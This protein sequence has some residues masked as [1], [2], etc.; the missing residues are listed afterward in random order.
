MTAPLPPGAPQP[1]GGQGQRAP[2]IDWQGLWD[3][4]VTAMPEAASQDGQPGWDDDE[5]IQLRR[6]VKQLEA[7]QASQRYYVPGM[8]LAPEAEWLRPDMEAGYRLDLARARHELQ[9]R[10]DA[11]RDL[12]AE[13]EA[14]ARGGRKDL[15]YREL[16]ALPKPVWVYSELL[17]QGFH[18]LAGPPEAGKSLLVRNWL[19]EIAASG[20]SVVFV[21]SEGQFDMAERFGSH[22][23]IT[24]AAPH[25]FFL[26]GGFNLGS[27]SDLSWFCGTYRD[28]RPALIVFDMIYGFG[29][30]DDNGVKGVA[31]V[32]N[33]GKQ[34]AADLSAAVLAVG[35]PGL[36]G[37]RRFRGSSMWRGS[38]DTEW[39]MADGQFTCEK[40]KY[41]DKRRMNWPYT[42]AW[43]QLRVLSQGE[44]LS[45]FSTRTAAIAADIKN[46]PGDSDASRAR[47]LAPSLGCSHDHA[48]KL[49][50]DWKR[51]Q[52]LSGD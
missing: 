19:C 22:P 39:H 14:L 31:P 12:D 50:R 11:I 38:F 40:H 46:Y 2:P 8:K 47:R 4:A 43:P 30:P 45:R 15:S 33:G 6:R 13:E 7:S 3:A 36:N 52:S 18:G 51:A 34:I 17:T 16:L 25:L 29:L 5:L 28:R 27:P 42:V 10:R 32:I 21:L 41:A 20:R 49:V 26:D 24:A 23:A 9:V 1:P 48:R 37:E 44:V 35:H